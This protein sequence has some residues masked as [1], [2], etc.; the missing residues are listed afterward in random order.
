MDGWTPDPKVAAAAVA[1]IVVW[2]VQAV[3]GVDVPPGIEGAVAVLVAYFVP[4]T[5]TRPLE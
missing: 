2:L 3:A 4:S 1:A 5:S